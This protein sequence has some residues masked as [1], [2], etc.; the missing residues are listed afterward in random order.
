MK[1]FGCSRITRFDGS[2]KITYDYKF[3]REP[4]PG[5][6]DVDWKDAVLLP[7][8]SLQLE[9]LSFVERKQF[10]QGDWRNLYRPWKGTMSATGVF[11]ETTTEQLQPQEKSYWD[12]AR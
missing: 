3:I 8:G 6:K 11:T 9:G 10:G 4:N 7:D 12:K 5:H 1:S 2:G